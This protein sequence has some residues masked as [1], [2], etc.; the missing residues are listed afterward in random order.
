MQPA[1]VR[2]GEIGMVEAIVPAVRLTFDPVAGP[3]LQKLV[4][5][6]AQGGTIFEYGA[7]ATEPTPFPLFEA[8]AHGANVRGYV[9]LSLTQD[10]TAVEPAKKYVY[11]RLA[12]G[13]FV[14][15]IAKTFPFAQALEAY[16]YLESNQQIGKIVLT[17]P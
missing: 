2:K 8:L 4:A 15:K 9:M 17:V 3:F 7:L 10:P 5:A 16:R 1:T 14:P 11:D 13:R 6:T 12:D